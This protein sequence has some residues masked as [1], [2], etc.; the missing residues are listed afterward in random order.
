MR[1]SYSTTV[2]P[3]SEKLEFT[4]ERFTPECPR[5][6]SYEHFHRYALAAGF[7]KGSS[8]LDAA[9]GEGYGASLLAKVATHV[10]GMDIAHEAIEHA[11]ARY[12]ERERLRFQQ[13]DVTRLP[14]EDDSFDRVVS[15]ETLEHMEPQEALLSEFRRVLK[16]D[17]MLL[18]SCPDKAVYTDQLGNENEFHVRELYRDELDALIAREFPACRLLGQKLM[19]HSA[20]WQEGEPS[21]V[22]VQTQAKEGNIL[23]G[24]LTGAPVYLIALCAARED[25]LP[26]LQGRLWLF[27]DE[28][29]S[30][31]RHYY[32]EI[33]KNMAAGE[34]LAARDAEI[35]QLKRQLSDRRTRGW[36]RWFRRG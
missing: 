10:V 35:E 27:G 24:P 21:R 32:H 16:P 33:R 25:L 23:Q 18:L 36:R 17:G 9:C 3:V 28:E 8:V 30:V 6:I 7:C 5:E 11:S 12:G 34:L 14:F 26:D 2:K 1:P 13:G 15:F 22:T 29:E 31:Y 19:F 4:G 20:I